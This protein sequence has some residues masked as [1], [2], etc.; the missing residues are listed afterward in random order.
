MTKEK[1]STRPPLSAQDLR[2][3]LGEALNAYFYGEFA[4]LKSMLPPLLLG[5]LAASVFLI[6][7]YGVPE[8]EAPDLALS[9]LKILGLLA[10]FSIGA[11]FALAWWSLRALGAP[12]RASLDH[13]VRMRVSTFLA[14]RATRFPPGHGA[15]EPW[16]AWS[17]DLESLSQR[18]GSPHPGAPVGGGL[19]V[20]AA[21]SLVGAD[22]VVPVL[23]EAFSRT[24]APLAAELAVTALMFGLLL[25]VAALSMGRV[26]RELY[27]RHLARALKGLSQ[28]ADDQKRLIAYPSS[29]WIDVIGVTGVV[30]V[31]LALVVGVVSLVEVGSNSC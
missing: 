23:G 6:V 9:I 25:V 11:G 24:E 20:S 12:I 4:I 5:G 7:G 16:M 17:D 15:R 18:G 10:A 27:E 21:A 14:R 19:L 1:D 13:R 29:L 3:Q 28:D 2:S 22:R 8:D 26:N 31:A 30:L